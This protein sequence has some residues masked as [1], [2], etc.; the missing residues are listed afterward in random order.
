LAPRILLV[1]FSSIGDVLLTTPLIRA[2]RTRHPDAWITFVTKTSF[3]PLL[4]HNRRL[5][6]LIGY[7]PAKPLRS[8]ARHLR[9]S[10]FTHRLDLH[11][12]LRTLMLRLLVPGRWSG[13]PKHRLARSI[14]IRTKRDRYRDRRPVPERYFDAARGL[15]V[16]PDGQSLEFFLRKDALDR[17]G[18]FLAERRLGQGRTLVALCPGAQHATKRWPVRRWQELATRLTTQGSDVVVLGG[19]TERELG[20]DVAA[21]GAESAASVAG[22]VELG[23]SAAF[24]K[25][26]R[27][28]VSGDTGLLHLAT[29]VGTPVVGLYGPTVAAFGFYPYRARATIIERDLTCRPCSAMGGPICPL[30][31][32]RCL[33]DTT[34][35][36]VYEAIRRLPR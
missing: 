17:A 6:E 27:C 19:P 4:E 20:L 31:H 26:A 5:D 35:E 12:S 24:L 14:L 3:L 11:G 32:H 16:A 21:A 7:D 29:A 18:A 2:I 9:Q 22:M 15:D 28:A 23:D 10:K 30:G 13:Y 8:L 36:E 25:L 34:V 33:V 1:R